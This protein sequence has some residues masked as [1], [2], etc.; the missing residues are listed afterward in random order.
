MFY[1][2]G[3]RQI[4]CSKTAC[5][6]GHKLKHRVRPGKYRYCDLCDVPAGLLGKRAHGF[7][8]C[9]FDVCDICY[10]RLPETTNKAPLKCIP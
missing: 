10:D 2:G 8:P 3:C 9:D 6:L 4:P 5:P 7:C 1:C